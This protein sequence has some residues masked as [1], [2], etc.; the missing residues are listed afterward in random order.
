MMATSGCATAATGAV[1]LAEQVGLATTLAIWA[2][3]QT[4][5]FVLLGTPLVFTLSSGWIYQRM[6]WGGLWGLLFA[7]PLF[8]QW[9]QKKR[10]L[11]FSAAPAFASL[12]F[13]L[14]FKDNQGMLGLELGPMMPVL[15]IL[16]SVLW[17]Y[18]AGFWL[19]YSSDH[20]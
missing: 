2:V 18:L 19:D 12:V 6:V 17:G 14:P 8:G 9:S 15:V 1:G 7:I 20:V 4:G 10:G 13:F 11:L 3:S 5:I 16:F